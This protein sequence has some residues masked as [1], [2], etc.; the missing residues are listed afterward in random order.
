MQ[1][2]VKNNTAFEFKGSLITLTV[3]HLLSSDIN[4]FL[5]QL[6]YHA[7]KTPNLFKNMPLVIDLQRMPAE[8]EINFTALQ[9]HLREHGLVPVGVRHGNEKHNNAAQLAGLAI[10]S[11]QVS[12]AK[13]KSSQESAPTAFAHTQ[14]ITKP[15]RSGQQI[16]ARQGNLIVLAPVSHGAE[17]LADGH[18]H[19]YGALHGR[20]LAGVNG[21]KTARIF[22]QKLAAELVSIAG[23]YSLSDNLPDIKAPIAQV[24]L[25]DDKI[26]A[27]G[28]G[29][30]GQSALP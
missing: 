24:F 19:V 10:L 28:L 15:V 17:L 13:S 12:K 29:V 6:R 9:H 25:E 2:P 8:D 16:Y 23:Y 1:L 18:I 7:Q 21:D 27:E 4:L 3:L 26:R 5:A 20:A 22:C 30:E 14:V 11:N